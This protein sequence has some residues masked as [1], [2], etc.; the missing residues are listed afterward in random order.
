MFYFDVLLPE[1]KQPIGNVSINVTFPEDFPFDDMQ[2]YAG[3][4]GVQDANNKITFK[5]DEAKA[6]PSP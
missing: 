1:W 6:Y 2:C 4:F 5:A 3:Q